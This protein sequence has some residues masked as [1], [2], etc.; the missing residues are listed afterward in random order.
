MQLNR[1]LVSL[2]LTYGSFRQD[3]L[4]H[5]RDDLTEGVSLWASEG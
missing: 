3:T 5:D 1:E 2:D 4:D